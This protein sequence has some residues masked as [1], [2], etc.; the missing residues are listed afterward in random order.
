M[1]ASRCK[2][3]NNTERQ[4]DVGAGGGGGG[5][6]GGGEGLKGDSILLMK[7]LPNLAYSVF[8]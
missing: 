5:G 4:R 7:G 1:S 8:S 3:Q 6:G 2:V